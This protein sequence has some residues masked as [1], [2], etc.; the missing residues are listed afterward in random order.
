MLIWGTGLENSKTSL[1][2][3]RRNKFNKQIY[4]PSYYED[5]DLKLNR[6]WFFL[7]IGLF[8]DINGILFLYID[9]PYKEWTLKNKMYDKKC[10]LCSQIILN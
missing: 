3:V 8:K 2:W 1:D 4:V 10:F 6:Y 5:L 7:K 9:L